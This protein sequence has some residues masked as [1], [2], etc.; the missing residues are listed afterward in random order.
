MTLTQNGLMKAGT[1]QGT[2]S[3]KA[4]N[5]MNTTRLIVAGAFI[6]RVP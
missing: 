6:A 1:D 5:N 4:A 3:M 2:D